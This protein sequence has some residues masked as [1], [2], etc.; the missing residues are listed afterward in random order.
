MDY[1]SNFVKNINDTMGFTRM[2]VQDLSRRHE[3]MR[4]AERSLERYISKNNIFS[5]NSS[6]PNLLYASVP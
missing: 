2:Q 5:V 3:K 1:R 4:E 6:Q